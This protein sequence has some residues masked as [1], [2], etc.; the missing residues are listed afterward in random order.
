MFRSLSPQWVWGS[1]PLPRPSRVGVR[2]LL[3]HTPHPPKNPHPQ[4]RSKEDP[5]EFVSHRRVYISQ[6]SA[7]VGTRSHTHMHARTRVYTPW[8]SSSDLAPEHFSRTFVPVDAHHGDRSTHQPA[9]ILLASLAH[10]EGRSCSGGYPGGACGFP[11]EEGPVL[12]DPGPG[13][14]HRHVRPPEGRLVRV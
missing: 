5:R 4:P 1:F 8:G 14:P 13:E 9:G 10:E 2:G 7:H 11:L 6:Y 12:V 3:P